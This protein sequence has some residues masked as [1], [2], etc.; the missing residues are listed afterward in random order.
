MI[1]Y[2]FGKCISPFSYGTA[3]LIRVL[4]QQVHIVPLGLPSMARDIRKFLGKNNFYD[5]I[6]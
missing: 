5:Q 1:E 4:L 2:M 6:I 3:D